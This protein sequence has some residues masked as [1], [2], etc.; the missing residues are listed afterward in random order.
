MSTETR[1]QKPSAK[2]ARLHAIGLNRAGKPAW[3]DNKP[4]NK[5]SQ[6]SAACSQRGEDNNQGIEGRA[7]TSREFESTGQDGAGSKAGSR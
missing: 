7:P 2:S 4:S 3:A 6:Q 5:L 1:N